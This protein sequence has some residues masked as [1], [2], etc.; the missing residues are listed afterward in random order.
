MLQVGATSIDEED[1]IWFHLQNRGFIPFY[2]VTFLIWYVQ[3]TDIESVLWSLQRVNMGDVSD[4]SKVH[5]ASIFGVNREDRD[6]MYLR[7]CSNIT[8]IH[9]VYQSKNRIKQTNSVALV[10][11][12]TIS[13]VRPPLVGEVSAKFSG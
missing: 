12:R 6:S 3:A 11:K 7:K 13:T 4:V 1:F 9:T 5:T 8:H 2:T 10:R